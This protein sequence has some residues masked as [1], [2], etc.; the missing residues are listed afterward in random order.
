[1]ED[2]R[3]DRWPPLGREDSGERVDVRGVRAQAVDGLGGEG[4]EAAREQDP[5]GLGD[6]G[7]V[8]PAASEV[9]HAGG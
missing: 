6:R 9:E 2:E 8:G 1:M 7:I 3:V 5:R 4:D